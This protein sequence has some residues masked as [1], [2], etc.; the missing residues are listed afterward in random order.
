MPTEQMVKEQMVKEKMMMRSTGACSP[1]ILSKIKYNHTMIGKIKLEI[2]KTKIYDPRSFSPL[3]TGTW[4][5]LCQDCTGKTLL[6]RR[7]EMKNVLRVRLK[8]S[9]NDG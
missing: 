7:N 5:Y 8:Q 3:N 2:R 9:D 4:K 6:P 1:M